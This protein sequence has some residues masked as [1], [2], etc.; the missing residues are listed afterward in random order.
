MPD[1]R[2]T[3]FG[4]KPYALLMNIAYIMEHLGEKWLFD[5]ESKLKAKD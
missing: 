1:I 4:K 2:D 3:N 5:F